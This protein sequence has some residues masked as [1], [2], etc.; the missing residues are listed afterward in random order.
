MRMT[1]SRNILTTLFIAAVV[2]LSFLVTSAPA[3]AST[4]VK[5]IVSTNSTYNTTAATRPVAHASFL[6]IGTIIRVV[7]YGAKKVKK[8]Y[9]WVLGGA[10]AH[11][12]ACTYSKRYK[13]HVGHCS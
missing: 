10:D 5:P 4:P 7:K 1:F 11:N 12:G 2:G 8:A 3:Q 9:D 13:R 6:G